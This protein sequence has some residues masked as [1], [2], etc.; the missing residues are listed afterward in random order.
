MSSIAF[1][2][3]GGIYND[4]RSTKEIIALAE[5][6]HTVKVI[7]WDRSG[8]AVGKCQSIFEKYAN[9]V[10]FEFYS[11]KTESG[12]G[13][14]NITKFF[15]WFKYV[16]KTL[17][18]NINEIE[19]IHACDLDSGWP[20]Y[21][22]CK[23]TKKNLTYDIFDYYVDSHSLPTALRGVVEK[24]E[25]SVINYAQTT[26]I[27]TEERREQINKANFRKVVVIHNSPD[28]SEVNLEVPLIWDYAY[29]GAFVEDRLIE[30]TLKGYKNNR[31][32]HFLFAGG[33]KYQNLAEECVKDK[34]FE[35]KGKIPYSEVLDNEARTAVLSAI[36]SPT[37]RN[38][39]LCAPNKFYEALALG[40]PV[41]VCK[42]T[43]ID[44]IVEENNLGAVI[45]YDVDE[46]YAALRNLLFDVKKREE[47]GVRAKKVYLEKYNWDIMKRRLLEIYG[48]N[49]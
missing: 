6:G 29:C 25:I 3:A 28:I 34:N 10:S 13:I 39:R 47:M 15:S 46:F 1:I 8:E 20:A 23:K 27:C 12:G 19:W 45:N 41:I 36:Y 35:Y 40:K 49:D 7:G 43:G 26:I 37:K 5:A 30:E 17:G 31:D 48:N 4:S 2:R 18:K 11:R 9:R 16:E 32:L 22:I 44:R 24:M 14:K 33:G 21:R 38:H 42:G